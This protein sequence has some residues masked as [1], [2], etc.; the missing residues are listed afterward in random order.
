MLL[1]SKVLSFVD[2]AICPL[3][4]SVAVLEIILPLPLVLSSIDMDVDSLP[5]G[6]VI[7]PVSLVHITVDVSE[8]SETMGSVVLPVA[9]V[10]GTI[11]PNLFPEAVTEATHPLACILGTRRVGVS[12]SLLSSRVRI[13]W[14][15]RNGLFLFNCREVAAVSSLRL[16]N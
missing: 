3:L 15:V 10:A 4:F 5:V 11:G 14:H 12:R 1:S 7:D 8:L 13:E 9:F 2:G 16:G 6:L